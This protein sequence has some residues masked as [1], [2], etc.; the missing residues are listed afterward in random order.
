MADA[1][2][3]IDPKYSFAMGNGRVPSVNAERRAGN[4]AVGAIGGAVLLGPLG[5]IAG[6]AI[7]GKRRHTF[8]ARRDH[9]CVVFDAD[10]VAMARFL[11]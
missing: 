6:A 9:I 11:T 10:P 3:V 1:P 8:A 7:G 2:E 4:A 5:A